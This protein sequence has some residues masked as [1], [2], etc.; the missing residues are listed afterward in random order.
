MKSLADIG[1]VVTEEI[2]V[3]GN[4]GMCKD[5]IEKAVKA[6]KGVDSASWDSKTKMLIVSYDKTIVKSEEIHQAIAAAGHDTEIAKASNKTYNKLHGC[7]KYR[8]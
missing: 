4:C 6:I 2:K 3:S 1:D 8:Q 5:R 7:C